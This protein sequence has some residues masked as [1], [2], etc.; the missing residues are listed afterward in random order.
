MSLRDRFMNTLVPAGWNELRPDQFAR[1]SDALHRVQGVALKAHITW[2]L[3]DM[4]WRTPR[5]YAT[6]FFVLNAEGR[7]RMTALADPFLTTDKLTDT[8]LPTLTAGRTVL[9][10]CE[11][12]LLN[13]V[14]AETW[15]MADTFFLRF[16]KTK[17]VGMLRM[18]AAVL[19]ATPG[20]TRADRLAFADTDLLAKVPEGQLMALHV[21]WSGH[22]KVYEKESPEPFRSVHQKHATRLKRGWSDVLRSLSNGTFGPFNTTVTTPA[23]LFLRELNDTM[24]ADQKRKEEATKAKNRR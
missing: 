4:S 1:I 22:R 18:M 24:V 8:L 7:H 12:D 20:T 9:H 19:Y 15:G 10:C 3:L 5:R 23:R 2:A 16:I 6:F 14:D 17:D 11:K 21:M 13:Q